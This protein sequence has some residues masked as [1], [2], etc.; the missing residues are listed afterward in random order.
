VRRA[1]LVRFGALGDVLLLRRAVFALRQA[2]CR[3]TLLA[4]A[5]SGAVLVGPG[6]TE[7]D[8]LLDWERADFAALLGQAP[9]SAGLRDA[10]AADVAVA[11]SRNPTLIA[12][13]RTVVPSVAAQDP[14]PPEG[15][16]AARWL[17]RPLVGLN[18]ADGAAPP[19]ALE[20]TEDEARAAAPWLERLP[21]GFLAVHP[22]SGSPDKNWPA[23]R[24][25]GLIARL[26]AGRP[27]L[28]VE[29]PAD[30]A[31]AAPLRAVAG[32]VV[33]YDLAPRVL[34]AL[35]RP[36]GRYVGNDSGVTHLAAASGAPTTAIFGPSDPVRWAPEGARVVRAPEGK[37]DQLDVETVAA[38]ART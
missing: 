21:A 18:I 29:G 30:R 6:Q 3:V 26:A 20:F 13:L 33:A 1:L 37:L 16:P 8:T 7:V 22:G 24:F 25:A 14:A 5:R 36:A 34:A 31:A 2:E 17:C 15:V 23:D 19:P 32:V 12:Q 38:A 35:L 4:P 11:Y 9:L 28:L 27:W 10:L